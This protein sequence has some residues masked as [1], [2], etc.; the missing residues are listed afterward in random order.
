MKTKTQPFLTLFLRELPLIALG[1]FTFFFLHS[2]L[3]PTIEVDRDAIYF[4]EVFSF[5]L[6][7]IFSKEKNPETLVD[8]VLEAQKAFGNDEK[9]EEIIKEV[10]SQG[11]YEDVF[12]TKKFKKDYKSPHYPKKDNILIFLL[13]SLTI[14]LLIFSNS[15]E[16]NSKVRLYKGVYAFFSLYKAMLILG[17]IQLAGTVNDSSITRAEYFSPSKPRYF[18]LQKILTLEPSS[19]TPLR[20]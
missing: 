5:H 6:Q 4:D 13:T 14:S 16:K 15:P 17:L 3:P 10:R 18:Q 20:K 1:V 19:Y 8:R 12:I 2:Q 7:E 9:K 11:L